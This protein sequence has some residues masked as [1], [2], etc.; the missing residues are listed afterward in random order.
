M[1][2]RREY[3]LALDG[4]TGSFRAILF[5]KD[6]VQKAIEQIE[7]EH[8]VYDE[9]PG[10]VGFDF[11]KNW[12]IIQRCI[13]NLIEKNN[14]A[15]EDIKGISTDS[16]REGFIL[17][18][19]NQK[20]LIGFSNID[21]RAKEEVISLKRE[22]PT[23]EMEIYLETGETFALSAVPRLLWV[24]KNKPELYQKAKYMNMINDWIVFKLTG[25][26]VSEPSNSSTSGLFDLA[27]REWLPEV[28]K[29]CGLKDDIFPPVYESGVPVGNVSAEAARQTGL[30]ESTVVVCGGGDSQLG[31]IG[32]GSIKPNQAALFGGSFWQYEFNTDKPYVDDRGRIRENCHSVPSVWQQEAIAWSSGLVMRWFRDAFLDLDVELA[33]QLGTSVYALMDQ[34]A[35]EIPIGCYGMYSIFADVMNF[36]NLKHA[37][38]TFTNFSIDP[39]KFNKA[40]FY[41]SI[42]ENAGLITLGHLKMVEEITGNKPDELFFAGGSAYSELWSQTIADILGIR[43]ITPKEKEATALGAAF[44]AG[45]GSGVYDNLEETTQYVQID[46]VYEPDMDNHRKYLEIFNDW[47]VLYKE[48]LNISDKGLTDYMWIAP[49]SE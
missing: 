12:E 36:R 28:A 49:G 39:L 9:Y 18:D 31:C 46:K 30:S 29:K 11:E 34:K 42:M 35:K 4:G 2:E 22:H 45:I 16:M 37:S 26:I 17:Y 8:P 10:S 1:E 5:Q 43:V 40:T 32:V 7:W 27:K 25:K 41:K 44:L 24:Q 3:L 23:L 47:Q 15:P 13:R 33:K 21:A 20:E 6:G 38:P 14:I 48:L 19:E